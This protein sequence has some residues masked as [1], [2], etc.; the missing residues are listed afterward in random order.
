[1]LS[2]RKP[3][4]WPVTNARQKT[5]LFKCGTIADVKYRRGTGMCFAVCHAV[6]QNGTYYDLFN[7]GL[8]FV[9]GL[10]ENQSLTQW[11]TILADY[12]L[13][14]EP[15]S[16]TCT[17]AFYHIVTYAGWIDNPYSK[18]FLLNR[19]NLNAD[20][21]PIVHV[22]GFALIADQKRALDLTYQTTRCWTNDVQV[23]GVA[24]GIVCLLWRMIRMY[25]FSELKQCIMD[26]IHIMYD[27]CGVTLGDVK[28]ID[29][30]N[31][32]VTSLFS[33]CLFAIKCVTW[34]VINGEH[35][36]VWDVMDETL[37]D[38]KRNTIHLPRRITDALCMVCAAVFG[39]LCGD[40]D[41]N[42]NPSARE[43]ISS[44]ASY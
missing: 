30:N 14:T 12:M 40:R 41:W 16:L 2:R 19:L 15:G 7:C 1:M 5:I 22:L 37:R 43:A 33:L 10:G 18:L 36:R 17:D 3:R 39:A 24:G 44:A 4:R 34:C 42:S 35:G 32:A 27:I 8:K 26:A 28:C 23:L 29:L 6:E 13:E 31:P 20:W 38:I 9:S 21:T 11:T 25:V